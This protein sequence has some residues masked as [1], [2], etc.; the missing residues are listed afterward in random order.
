MKIKDLLKYNPELEITISARDVDEEK[1][2][3]RRLF[4]TK[5]IEVIKVVDDDTS[6]TI[7]A[8][9]KSNGDMYEA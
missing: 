1:Y 5:I 8:D 9:V 2:P 6:I 7:V 4:S 3:F